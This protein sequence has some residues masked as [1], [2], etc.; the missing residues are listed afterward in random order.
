MSETTDD[1]PT[2]PAGDG[3]GPDESELDP[4]KTGSDHSQDERG[5]AG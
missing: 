2:T 1:G 3:T 5:D 4:A